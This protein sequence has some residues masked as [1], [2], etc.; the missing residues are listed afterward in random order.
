MKRPAL[1]AVKAAMSRGDW[2]SPLLVGAMLHEAGRC[3]P[4]EARDIVARYAEALPSPD[5]AP[6]SGEA[7]LMAQLQ[8]FSLGNI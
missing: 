3:E 5:P 1:E 8:A 4:A 2:P 7:D 6:G